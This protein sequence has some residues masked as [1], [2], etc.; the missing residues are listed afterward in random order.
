MNMTATLTNKTLIVEFLKE[1][2]FTLLPTIFNEDLRNYIWENW[3]RYLDE[4][5]V[6]WTKNQTDLEK[7]HKLINNQHKS[8]NFMKA[9]KNQL[10][11]LYILVIKENDIKIITD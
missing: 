9:N 4:Y 1:K 2:L 5:S 7:F 10:L 3:K 8:I 6:Y 11:Y